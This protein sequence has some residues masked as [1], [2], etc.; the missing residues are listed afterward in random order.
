[1]DTYA[2][3]SAE[4]GD[5]PSNST[6]YWER[7]GTSSSFV[8]TFGPSLGF[9][10]AVEPLNADLVR[11]AVAVRAVDASASRGVRWGFRNLR[12]EVPVGKP[13][14]WRR[15]ATALNSLLGLLTGDTWDVRFTKEN[16][17]EE[18]VR[19]AFPGTSQVVLLSGGADSG[20]GAM[21]SALSLRKGQQQSLVSHFSTGHISPIQQRLASEI[22]AAAPDTSQEHIRLNHQRRK[23]GPSGARYGRESSSRSRSLLFIALGLAAASIERVPLLIPENGFASINP[24]LGYDRRGSLSTK[25]THPRFFN[26]LRSLL[27][28]VGGH[29]AFSNPYASTTKG[30]MFAQL[31][32]AMGAQAAANY[33]SLT[34]S[35]SHSGM[36]SYGVYPTVQCGVCFGCVLRRASFHAAGL[37]DQSEYIDLKVHQGVPPAWLESHSVL[38]ALRSF[39]DKP[40]DELALAT[41]R[42]PTDYSIADAKDLCDRAI[43]E[44]RGYLA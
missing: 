19:M 25:T 23:H 17:P 10:G 39:V 29:A 22:A 30:E 14:R 26:E 7:A 3:T 42:L 4:P 11:I 9:L 13:K 27:G 28:E 8:S 40:P 1:M 33:L 21:L 16:F 32:D 34:N 20:A 35:C 6:F 38:G 5:D 24:P 43:G 31:R 18:A 15:Q 12:V 36:R 44:L 37:E 2:L 41:M